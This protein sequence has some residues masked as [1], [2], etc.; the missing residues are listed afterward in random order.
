VQRALIAN[1]GRE[2][3]TRQLGNGR[4]RA[5]FIAAIGTTE[6]TFPGRSGVLLT[7]LRFASAGGGPMADLAR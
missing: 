6:R 4:I 1:L 7:R 5:G 3:T 2:L